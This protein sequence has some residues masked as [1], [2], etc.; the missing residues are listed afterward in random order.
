MGTGRKRI[1]FKNNHAVPYLLIIKGQ[2]TDL[3]YGSGDGYCL[4][5]TPGKCPVANL[6]YALSS[7]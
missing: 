6:P 4:H 3:F 1:S 5:R 2:Q 7:R